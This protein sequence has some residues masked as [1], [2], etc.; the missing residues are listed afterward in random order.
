MGNQIEQIKKLYSKSKVYKIPKNP[1][2]GQE[3][4][5]VTL[6]AL[7][8]KDLSLLNDMGE[9]LPISELTKNAEILFARSLQITEEEVSPISMEFMEDL[10]VAVTEL[11][12]LKES[13]IKKIGIKDFIEKK[14][15]Q[16]EA[17]K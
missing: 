15:A 11:N 14:K 8:L 12:N 13:D 4:I 10:L 7:S 3:Q 6:T 17:S 1:R 5:D 16:I 2:E 9:D